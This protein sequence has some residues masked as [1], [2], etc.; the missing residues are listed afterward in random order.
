MRDHV[1]A[2]LQGCGQAKK[3]QITV[4]RAVNQ[5]AVVLI[6]RTFAGEWCISMSTGPNM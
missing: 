4:E 2:A 6:R 3:W 1:L 5:V